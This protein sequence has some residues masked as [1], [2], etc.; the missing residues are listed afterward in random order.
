MFKFATIL[1]FITLQISIIKYYKAL[2]IFESIFFRLSIYNYLQII[3][4]RHDYNALLLFKNINTSYQISEN[5]L[6]THIEIKLFIETRYYVFM[7]Y[8]KVIFQ[9]FFANMYYKLTNNI[10]IILI[11][12]YNMHYAYFHSIFIFMR[13]KKS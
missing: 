1:I 3:L 12:I 7:N 10:N 2:Y 11:I 8:C 5:Y 4:Y 9:I 6:I 13:F